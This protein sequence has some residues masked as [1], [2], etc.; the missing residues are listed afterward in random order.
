LANKDFEN[1]D[2]TENDQLEKPLENLRECKEGLAPSTVVHESSAADPNT[3]KATDK[4]QLMFGD[5]G[6]L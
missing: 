4:V 2:R 3:S 1:K 6:I 5:I